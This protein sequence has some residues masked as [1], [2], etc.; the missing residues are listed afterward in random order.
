MLSNLYKNKWN[1]S[2]K[3]HDQDQTT[4]RSGEALQKVGKWC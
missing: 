2:L 3:L 4:E 1:N